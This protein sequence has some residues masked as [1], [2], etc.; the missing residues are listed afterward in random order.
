MKNIFEKLYNLLIANS[1][2][3]DSE[4]CKIIGNTYENPELL[5]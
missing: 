3:I 1:K 4:F 2:N 5:Q